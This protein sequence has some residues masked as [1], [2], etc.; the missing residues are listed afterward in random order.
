MN[1]VSSTDDNGGLEFVG[2]HLDD[3][4]ETLKI[5]EKQGRGIGNLQGQGRVEHIGGCQAKMEKSRCWT[6]MLRDGG[7]EGDHI[8][9]HL[10]FDLLNAIHGECCAIP[11]V[12]GILLRDDA[13]LSK[14]LD[15]SQFNVKPALIFVLITPDRAHFG[16]SV[17]WNHNVSA[18]RRTLM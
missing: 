12:C 10:G 9:L 15:Y 4:E 8:V 16:A 11:D 1:T 18:P 2:A 14:G 7:G 5:F 13:M 6:H 3:I 17:T